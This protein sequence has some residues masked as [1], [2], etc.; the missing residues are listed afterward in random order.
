M[1]K[2]VTD[3]RSKPP[4][5]APGSRVPQPAHPS[6]MQQPAGQYQQP[7]QPAQPRAPLLPTG[8]PVSLTEFEKKGL[9]ALGIEGAPPAG[10]ADEIAKLRAE[11]PDMF[12]PA[13]PEGL[14]PDHKVKVGKEVDISSLSEEHKRD[15]HTFVSQQRA[16]TVQQMEAAQKMLPNAP[17][18]VNEAITAGLSAQS[19]PSGDTLAIYD[20]ISNK[21][22]PGGAVSTPKRCTHCGFDMLQPDP[23]VVTDDDKIVFLAAFAAG[24]RF[25]KRVSLLGGN[26]VVGFREMTSAETD[27][28][29]RQ[30]AIDTRDGIKEQAIPGEEE[31]WGNFS[32]YSL[33]MCLEYVETT[34]AG[35]TELPTIGEAELDQPPPGQ[36]R[37]KP[38]L[39]AITDL[40][41][42]TDSLR[43][44]IGDAWHMFQATLNKIEAN[45]LNESFWQAIAGPR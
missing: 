42:S 36:T 21:D 35:R 17:P 4:V 9:S 34:S 43:R 22:S 6:Q 10:L 7:T 33:A 41:L 16:E 44:I 38:Y 40:V 15:I 37:L 13:L 32:T 23:L 45:A 26:L 20:D 3:L 19:G 30:V 31:L 14:A 24:D 5:S 25:R 29:Y 2:K 28:A 11:E 39:K 12:T 1:P 27:M 18:G 8:I